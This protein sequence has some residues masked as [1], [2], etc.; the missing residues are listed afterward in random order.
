MI[1]RLTLAIIDLAFWATRIKQRECAPAFPVSASVSHSGYDLPRR[2]T[3]MRYMYEQ[4]CYPPRKEAG[5]K[6]SCSSSLRIWRER[7]LE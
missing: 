3:L 5:G 1:F 7:S 4:A 6:T 2:N